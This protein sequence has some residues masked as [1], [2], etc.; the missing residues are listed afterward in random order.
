[1][2]DRDNAFKMMEDCLLQVFSEAVKMC[3]EISGKDD[4]FSDP[5]NCY[6]GQK[7]YAMA[8]L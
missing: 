8:F 1:M 7:L 2:T 6:I 5:K 4:Y 3:K